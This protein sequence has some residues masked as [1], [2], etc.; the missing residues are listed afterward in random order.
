MHYTRF[1]L[2]VL[3]YISAVY[4]TFYSYLNGYLFYIN[5]YFVRKPNQKKGDDEKNLKFSKKIS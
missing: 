2:T 5:T 3:C 1:L 4:F